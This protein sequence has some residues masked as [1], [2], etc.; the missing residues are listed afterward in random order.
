MEDISAEKKMIEVFWTG[1]YD[2][3]FR[4]CQL[5]K[6]DVVIQPY[7]VSDGRKSEEYERNA[8]NTI[9]RKLQNNNETK[10][11]IKE[12]KYISKEDREDAPEITKAFQNLLKQDFMGSQYEWLGTFA[13]K[14]K[15]VEMSIHKDDKA[16]E[17]ISK[18]GKLKV[19]E[20]EEGKYYVIDKDNSEKDCI[21]L[22]G[23]LHFPL[24][25]YTKVQ[26][27]EEYEK[28]GLSDIIDDTWFCFTPID[29][30]P[31]GQ[32]NPCKYTIEEGMAYRFTP[33]A[34]QRYK[35]MKSPV[36]RV[37]RKIKSIVK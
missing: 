20:G 24:V 18:H 1:G 9:T 5:S 22:F 34:I 8:I 17:L 36:N 11:T 23:N 12:I 7:Y 26:M 13:L 14:H 25:D 37:V 2:S 3:T 31:C 4:I 15:G 33:E 30:K 35:K 21:T 27:K 10:A 28:M 19:E 16:I 29:G 32:C 6:K